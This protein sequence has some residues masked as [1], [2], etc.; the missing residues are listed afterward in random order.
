[1]IFETSI[2]EFITNLKKMISKQTWFFVKFEL[3]FYCL[4]SLQK[5]KLI[6]WFFK[7][8][9]LKLKKNQVTLDISKIKWRQTRGLVNFKIKGL[10]CSY[11]ITQCT[12]TCFFKASVTFGTGFTTSRI[13][14]HHRF[15]RSIDF[16][17][18]I[19]TNHNPS[20]DCLKVEIV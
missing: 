17:S 8:D 5:F 9:I 19:L 6:F 14:K 10:N 16:Q 2:W 13:K 3:D 20:P 18:T 11:S 4:C 7:L 15:T 1:M 12:C